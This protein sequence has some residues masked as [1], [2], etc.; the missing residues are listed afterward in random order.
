VTE[1]VVPGIGDPRAAGSE[2]RGTAAQRLRASFVASLSW[3]ACRVPEGL[4]VRAADVVGELWYRFAPARAATGRR[5]LERVAAYLAA[6]GLGGDRV[7][8]A[9]NDPAALERLLRAAFRNAARYYLEVARTPTLGPSTIRNRL[10]IETP[11]VVERAFG[12]RKPVIFVALHFGAIELPA[13]LLAERTGI[14][15]TV[16]METIADPELQRYFVR[17]RGRVGLRIVGLKEARRELLAGLRRGE[18]VG[19]VGDRDLTGGGLPVSLFGAPAPLPAGPALL[20]IETGAPIYV[21]AVRRT[22]IGRYRGRLVEVAVPSDGS[23]RER[24][25]RTVES[26]ASAF[27]SIVA[28]APEQWWTVFFPIWPDLGA[29]RDGGAS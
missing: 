20:A 15:A 27:E 16:P 26:I 13:L 1:H 23:R 19:L 10:L 22:G 28:D 11:E 12:A 24:L 5:N 9:A 18:S 29:S 7:A 14:Q 2:R 21:A 8:S 25:T 17:S 6:R 4:A 3:L